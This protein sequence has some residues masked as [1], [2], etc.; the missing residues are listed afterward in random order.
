MYIHTCIKF[1]FQSK[2]FCKLTQSA[3]KYV[4][5]E[6]KYMLWMKFIS[7]SDANDDPG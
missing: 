1:D 5:K 7:F 4:C 6:L 2:E 3:V